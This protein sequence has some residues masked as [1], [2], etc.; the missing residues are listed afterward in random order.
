MTSSGPADKLTTGVL[1]FLDACAE[2]KLELDSLLI[3]GSGRILFERY[4]WPYRPELVHSVHSATKSFVGT[5]VG[6]AIAE[7]R[8]S[9]SDPLTRFFSDR[10]PSDVDARVRAI[11]IEDLL[12]MRTGHVEGISGARWRRLE[13]S[14]IDDF[15][16]A[17]FGGDPGSEFLYS[18]GSSHML[19]AIVGVAAGESVVDYLR[20]RLFEPLDF[21]G[22][23][24]DSDAEGNSSGGNGLSLRSIDFLKW[25][26]L[27]LQDGIWQ[28]RRVL[29]EGWVSQ[30][31]HP[32]VREVR[33]NR[34]EGQRYLANTED[35]DGLHAVRDGY[36]YQVWCGPDGSY[37]ASGMFGQKCLVLPR[38][39]AVI[40]VTSS[41]A[42]ERH[43][44]LMPLI[45]DILVPALGEADSPVA[46]PTQVSGAPEL[47]SAFCGSGKA[48]PTVD[49]YYRCTENQDGI[50]L[51][52][53]RIEDETVHLVVSD[54]RGRHRLDAG[55]G[56]WTDSSTTLTSWRLHHSYQDP[57]SNTVTGARWTALN[58]LLIDVYFIETPFHDTIAL[59]FEGDELTWRRSVNINSGPTEAERVHG[60]RATQSRSP[61]N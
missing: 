13:G 5:A 38:R 23:R 34:F 4:S 16:R 52:E 15:L 41:I 26:R 57:V 61:R 8:I 43:P 31:S 3:F 7:G 21:S 10:I 18:S 37:Y 49:G 46:L 20:P 54:E 51:I 56:H 17:P 35:A 24:W 11:T 30:M 44:Q 40:T 28:G 53:L 6:F 29:P 50:D 12:T 48:H 9:L 42:P 45:Q 22:Y 25:G 14:W 55:L 27:H 60:T 2:K 1:A 58:E 36:G 32:Y 59:T 33:P 47:E 19:S 39:N